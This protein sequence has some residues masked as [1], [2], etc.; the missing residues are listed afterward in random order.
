MNWMYSQ[1]FPYN[2]TCEQANARVLSTVYIL[3]RRELAFAVYTTYITLGKSGKS[4][5]LAGV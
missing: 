4:P 5:D 1:R 2:L 3:T